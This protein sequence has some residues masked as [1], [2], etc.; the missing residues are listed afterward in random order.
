MSIQV[1]DEKLSVPP[2]AASTSENL[3]TGQVLLPEVENVRFPSSCLRKNL[4][5]KH[6]AHNIKVYA[7]TTMLY[8]PIPSLKHVYLKTLKKVEIS[9]KSYTDRSKRFVLL[10]DGR[11]SN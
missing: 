9:F 10:V 2:R 1:C 7:L 3:T 11:I 5:K 6:E 4:L 8:T